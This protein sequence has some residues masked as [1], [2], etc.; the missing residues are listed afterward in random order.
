MYGASDQWTSD[1]IATRKLVYLLVVSKTRMEHSAHCAEIT[2][3]PAPT[4]VTLATVATH[5]FGRD[6]YRPRLSQLSTR[7]HCEIVRGNASG[8]LL[9]SPGAS[10]DAARVPGCGAQV[11]SLLGT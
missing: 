5:A 6:S 2:R 3:A 4:G 8:M 7:R 9:R 11:P 10:S 1:W